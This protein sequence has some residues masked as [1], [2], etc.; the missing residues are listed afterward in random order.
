MTR[1]APER[2]T[3]APVLRRACACG[4]TKRRLQ[5]R[6]AATTAPAMAPPIVHEVLGTPGEPLDRTARA[7]LEPALGHDFSQVRVHSDERAARSAESVGA[8]A[9]TVGH[10][11]VFAGG[12][13]R[14]RSEEGTRLIAHELAHVAQ[15]GDVRPT[16]GAPIAID[17]PGSPEERQAQAL[18]NA[19]GPVRAAAAGAPRLQRA[20]P[21]R[22]ECASKTGSAVEAIR[23][24]ENDPAQKQRIAQRRKARGRGCQPDGHNCRATKLETIAKAAEPG[25]IDVARGIF[26][27]AD[28]HPDTVAE[29]IACSATVPPIAAGGQCVLVPPAMEAR[30]AQFLQGAPTIGKAPRD[31]WAARV[32]SVI[33]HEMRHVRFDRER[34]GRPPPC[35][36]WD[37]YGELTEL[38]ARLDEVAGLHRHLEM[39][40]SLG[41]PTPG[42]APAKPISAPRRW[43]ILD[44]VLRNNV[45]RNI[46][47][48]TGALR[49]MRCSCGCPRADRL[50][51]EA[52]APMARGWERA[53]QEWMHG[54]LARPDRW[55]EDLGWML[56]PLPPPEAAAAGPP[57]PPPARPPPQPLARPP[58]PERPR[59]PSLIPIRTD[60]RDRFEEA[61]R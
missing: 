55:G 1:L 4:Q 28:M 44:T 5:R 38:L 53:T 49:R 59:F 22:A 56:P 14:P 61:D 23:D 40:G 18:A 41:D 36:S 42:N 19:A 45:S 21:T 58:E 3:P 57:G 51:R 39:R 43:A 47:N 29:A 10:H 9:Y 7:R 27:N 17:D 33:I 37:V 48:V 11:V 13:Y 46:V 32:V 26:I 15:Q 16:A 8:L 25:L 2:P 54:S 12:R 34:E 30:A 6:A 31:E 35:G 20:C 50:V 24:E 60:V 52:V